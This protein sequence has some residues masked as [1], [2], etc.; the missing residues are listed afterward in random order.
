MAWAVSSEVDLCITDIKSAVCSLLKEDKHTQT[1]RQ[2]HRRDLLMA[3]LEAVSVCGTESVKKPEST[4]PSIYSQQVNTITYERRLH[5][6]LHKDSWPAF[7]YTCDNLYDRSKGFITPIFCWRSNH[8]C[9]SGN[10]LQDLVIVFTVHLTLPFAL[11]LSSTT[12]LL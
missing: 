5:S 8:P 10:N 12:R 1:I 6:F 3:D 2:T 9:S 7:C 11:L 4:K